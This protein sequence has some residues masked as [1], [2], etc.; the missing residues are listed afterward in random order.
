MTA[1]YLNHQR[2]P[3][4][5]WRL[6]RSLKQFHT[7]FAELDTSYIVTAYICNCSNT[8]FILDDKS[9]F[10]YVCEECGNDRFLDA[11]YY[12]ADGL[13][14]DMNNHFSSSTTLSELCQTNSWE[15]YLDSGNVCNTF[16]KLEEKVRHICDPVLQTAKFEMMD[17]DGEVHY[18]YLY[19]LPIGI[20][21]AREKV[22]W[23]YKE[24]YSVG[25]NSKGDVSGRSSVA[26][27]ETTIKHMLFSLFEYIKRFDPFGLGSL[28]EKLES[29]NQISFFVRYKRLKSAEFYRWNNVAYLLEN[30]STEDLVLED[31]LDEII[32]HSK[33]KAIRKALF[34]NYELQKSGKDELSHKKNGYNFV[35]I[36]I[37]A[38]AIADTNLLV[39]FLNSQ[40]YRLDTT[41]ERHRMPDL[42][43]AKLLE[44][45]VEFLKSR[46][47]DNQIVA[48]FEKMDML[49]SN[50]DK[51]MFED[52]LMSLR[53]L[54]F[55]L[56][57]FEKPK[58]KI[59]DIHDELSRLA[60]A[61][62]HEKIKDKKLN[63][64]EDE[65]KACIEIDDF[66]VRL[67]RDGEELNRWADELRNCMGGYLDS[68]LDKYTTIYV[69]FEGKEPKFAVEIYDNKIIQATAIG[70][71]ELSEAQ[72]KAMY[73]W[74]EL[75]KK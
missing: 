24:I 54:G 43:Y 13:Y 70:N 55:E 45:F 64:T 9:G 60:R 21:F 42:Q 26:I 34:E 10:E 33:S 4:L 51:I 31:A 18:K 75:S 61:K 32:N 1:F 67:P 46:Y 73:K 27:D 12:A 71:S 66:E 63:Y 39:R 6:S 5:P 36:F 15:R 49:T 74:F 40:F 58:C 20:D 59:K 25:M 38:R 19:Y 53:E 52:S 17:G 44:G 28:R 8:Q 37:M 62:R 22:F 56:A 69:F 57:G 41:A 47:S 35:L 14:Y 7:L 50:H 29:L 16:H 65:L 72:Q 68:I 48:M 11:D 23:G 2:A 3:E 30:T